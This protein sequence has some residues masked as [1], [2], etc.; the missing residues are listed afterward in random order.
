[1]DRWS[2]AIGIANEYGIVTGYPD[3][4]FRP[5]A[6]ITREEAMAMYQRAMKMTNL[7][8]S[9]LN[10]YQS[11]TD[12]VEVSSWAETYV[13]DVLAA[14]VFNGTSVITIS[15]KSNLTYA[16]AAQAIKNLLVESKLIN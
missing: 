11:Y 6:R 7:I 15:P 4:T 14:N 5:D 12:Y 16:E 1:L 10:Q 13:K 9:D 3:G 2:L 8:G